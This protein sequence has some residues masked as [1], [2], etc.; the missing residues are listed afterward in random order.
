MNEPL[1]TLPALHP[2]QEARSWLP[3]VRLV[4]QKRPQHTRLAM[5]DAPR[6]AAGTA[7]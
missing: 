1:H 4:A 6:R 3:P 2:L 5:A 7:R